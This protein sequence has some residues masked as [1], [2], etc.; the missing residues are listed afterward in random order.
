MGLQPAVAA[1][2]MIPNSPALIVAAVLGVVALGGG[3]FL[4]VSPLVERGR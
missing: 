4:A 3:L 2:A 1:L